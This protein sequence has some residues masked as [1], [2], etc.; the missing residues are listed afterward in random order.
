MSKLWR[1]AGATVM[2]WAA[3]TVSAMAQAGEWP[4]SPELPNGFREQDQDVL[5]VRQEVLDQL[6]PVVVRIST[7]GITT[8]QFP[9]PLEAVDGDAVA[10]NPKQAPNAEL[11]LSPGP[12]WLSVKALREG[13]EQNLT[14]V[15]RG[16]IYPIVLRG[17]ARHDYAVLFSLKEDLLAAGLHRTTV[18]SKRKKVSTARLIGVLDRV[19]GY[20]T[21]SKTTPAMY[22]DCD[23]DEPLAQGRGVDETERVRS[24]IVRVLRDNGLDA[25]GFEVRLTN[26]TGEVVHYD[27][28][29]LAVRAGREVFQA[30]VWDAGGKLGP[31]E[32]QYAFF[33]VAGSAEST[34]ANDLSVYNEFHLVIRELKEGG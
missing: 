17:V 8:L 7:R 23:V 31:H 10:T 2:G 26:R 27:P 6:D 4:S 5:R 29:G 3:L 16:K 14:V 34:H 18:V 11:M 1:R 33:A 15:I 28:G 25:V 9:A 32:T 30:A 24:E 13:V 22:V 12:N 20:P 19:K 21:F